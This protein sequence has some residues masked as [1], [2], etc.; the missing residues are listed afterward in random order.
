M[1]KRKSSSSPSSSEKKYKQNTDNIDDIKT[2]QY[3]PSE[4]VDA[5]SSGNSSSNNNNNLLSSSHPNSNGDGNVDIN[6][7][8]NRDISNDKISIAEKLYDDLS[9]E[10][11]KTGGL[12]SLNVSVTKYLID[13]CLANPEDAIIF[14]EK[15]IVTK[16]LS[17][18]RS[19]Y[20]ENFHN[21][22]LATKDRAYSSRE[23]IMDIAY[24]EDFDTTL[25]AMDAFNLFNRLMKPGC[26]LTKLVFEDG[27]NHVRDP[28]D[29][30]ILP[31]YRELLAHLIDKLKLAIKYVS[32][33]SLK[34]N[35]K[36][37]HVFGCFVDSARRYCK[38][39]TKKWLEDA[40]KLLGQTIY[41]NAELILKL[42]K[43]L[44][45]GWRRVAKHDF[46]VNTCLCNTCLQCMGSN[47]CGS[48]P[49]EIPKCEHNV[50]A[51]TLSTST[52]TSSS[53]TSAS[54]S[55]SSLTS[56]CQNIF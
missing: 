35:Q 48:C 56:A 53:S 27:F 49:I 19:S 26:E 45:R 51:V 28:K 3:Y 20:L 1:N 40:E 36:S 39:V 4:L 17:Q 5:N 8:P 30:S 10:A 16:E 42:S 24:A 7:D 11:I 32:T 43:M 33:P 29:L 23:R 44:I 25:F 12:K 2:S 50:N 47:D 46:F 13:L 41:Q 14:K 52:S 15:G 22:W 18:L 9:P 55:T 34:M 37:E 31:N 38:L 21:L 54:T 6:N